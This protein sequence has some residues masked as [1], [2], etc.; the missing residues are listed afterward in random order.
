MKC[1]TATRSFRMSSISAS[2]QIS[3]ISYKDH[4]DFLSIYIAANVTNG[5][6][7]CYNCL[8]RKSACSIELNTKV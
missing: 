8:N 6:L 1:A 3:S 2:Y 7:T 4:A 5:V